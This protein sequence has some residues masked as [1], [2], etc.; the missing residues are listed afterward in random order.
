MS[1]LVHFSH[2]ACLRVLL[3]I[4][5][6]YKAP[7]AVIVLHCI[8]DGHTYRRHPIC[9]LT[10]VSASAHAARHAAAR[11][12]PAEAASATAADAADDTLTCDIAF[13]YYETC[14]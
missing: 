12:S 8:R 5:L 6:L 7:L 13:I 10:P 9:R 3:L 1:K 4:T 14:T 11:Q 2:I